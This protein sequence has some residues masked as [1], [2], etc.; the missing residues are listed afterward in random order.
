MHKYL[1]LIF[2]FFFIFHF[3]VLLASQ[4][5]QMEYLDRGVV[6]VKVTNGIALSWR[7]LGTDDKNTSFNVY[8]NNVKIHTSTS[9]SPTFY[10]DLSGLITSEYT[11][12]PTINNIEIP[13]DVI[14]KVKPWAQE[15]LSLQ[16][17][18]PTGGITPPN[19]IGSVGKTPDA[20]YPDGQNYTYTPN[21]MSV[22][23]LDGD[24]EYELIV[25]WYP[26]N[27]QD[28]SYFGITGKVYLDAYK[29]NGTFL[30]RIDLGMNIRAGAHYTQFM[31]Y[32]LDGDGKSE[33]VCKTAPGTIDGKGNYVLMN[34]D[35]PKADYRNLTYT[36]TS[37]ADM[38]GVV[39][40]GPEYLT[41]FDGATGAELHT[42]A[43]N[44]A[45]GSVSSW[46]DNYGNRVD[47]FL[48][49]VGYFEN[50]KPSVVMCRG[51]YT[52]AALVAYD[53][54]NKKLVER[55]YHNSTTSG[56]GAYGEG[57]HNL[58]VA[59]V[60]ADGKDEI[61]YGSCVIDDDGK[62]MYRTG[63]G[64]G[65]AMHVSDMD[66]DRPGLEVW[67]VHENTSSPYGYQLRD[68][69]TGENIWG[70]KSG[71]DVGRGMA[72]DIDARYRG[73]EMWSTG[74]SA[75]YDVKGNQ[76]STTR[77]SVNFR[78]YWDGDLQDELLD[79]VKITKWTGNGNTTLLTC[80]YYQSSASINSTKSNPC[81]SAD[82][83][84]DWREEIIYY[85]SADPSKINIFTST[86]NTN[87]RLYTLM[88]DP[89]YRLG[90][91]WQ[92]VAYNQPPHLG[93]YIGDGLANNPEPQIYT[94]KFK[95]EKTSI[96]SEK[97]Q[98]ASIYIASDK[99]HI[100]STDPVIQ[101]EIFSLTGK[102][103]QKISG[104]RN[105]KFIISLNEKQEIY[106]VR[107]MTNNGLQT[108]KVMR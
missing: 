96:K 46:G 101:V 65:D 7:L 40:N 85:N 89:V 98:T 23:D 87:N 83:L 103:I 53:V 6:A 91:A 17:Q 4:P 108:S 8:R 86:I 22:G 25:K 20:S 24:G 69:A 57:F 62:L 58:S 29:L 102:L 93:F 74:A 67:T 50:T 37:G 52:R 59:D 97:Y 11:V 14:K 60:D 95:D 72:G 78:I 99:L 2:A 100:C 77:P 94:P 1:F 39:I 84:G 27:A 70:T 44:P 64:H 36:A 63:I 73:F 47:R 80:S 16:L 54:V 30:W 61:I 49:C 66:P 76:I 38:L 5:R 28:N 13:D 34:N 31:V 3:S 19:Q 68:A 26:T 81:L 106:I 56:A 45:R 88:H 82:I 10:N 105:D 15:Y 107:L 21:D 35:D 51:Y 92:N 12:I 32:D 79:G 48:A 90:I 104:I 55:W 42:I 41:L 43:Y 71:T 75:T 18:R 33:L 9:T